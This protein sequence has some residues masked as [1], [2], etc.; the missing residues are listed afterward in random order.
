MSSYSP[1]LRLELITTGDQA[2]V[3][4]VTTNTN[5]GT[6]L[7]SAIA[8][9]TSVVI[10]TPSQS[11]TANFGAPDQSRFAVVALTGAGTD[12][13]VFV[14]PSPKMYVFKN[15]TSY[16]ATIYNSTALGNT[17][18]AGTGVAI[19]AGKTMA[20]WTDG[21]NVA[22]QNDYTVA[23]TYTQAAKTANT[24]LA[25]TAF[26]DG[27]RSLLTSTTSGGGTASSSDR[28]C[29]VSV[30]SGITI[31]AGVFSF[32]D[33]FTVY[34]SSSSTIT[35]TAGSGLG[36]SLVGT[37]TTGNRSVAQK[38]LAT[39]VFTGSSTCVVSGGGVS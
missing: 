16:T 18:V 36:M 5:L 20:V 3:W 34:N 32:G 24:T 29:L 39:V 19:P 14:P 17:V 21:T 26:A 23:T 31:P 15:V 22:N 25:S 33:V 8:G 38:G 9:Y 2:G 7:E 37:S 12:F 30:S 27:L 28:G 4:G 6:L 11:L 10:V 35:L 13:A 1:D